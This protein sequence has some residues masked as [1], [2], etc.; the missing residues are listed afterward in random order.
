LWRLKDHAAHLEEKVGAERSVAMPYRP[1]ERVP[2][3]WTGRPTRLA[4]RLLVR[5]TTAFLVGTVPVGLLLTLLALLIPGNAGIFMIIPVVPAML[6]G[7]N[8]ARKARARLLTRAAQR[9]ADRR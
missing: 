8:V 4:G 6:V 5:P 1:S 2:R 7:G 3:P 9:N